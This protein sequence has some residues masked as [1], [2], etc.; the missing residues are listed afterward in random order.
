MSHP[1]RPPADSAQ[2][3]R[4][5]RGI[6]ALV[7]GVAALVLQGDVGLFHVGVALALAL[8]VFELLG[9]ALARWSPS[10]NPDDYRS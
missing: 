4:L 1:A 8:L 10:K 9:W 7:A 2:L 6:G 5:R 3:D